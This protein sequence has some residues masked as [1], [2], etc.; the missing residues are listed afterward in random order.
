MGPV[1]IST[2]DLLGIYRAKTLHGTPENI[3]IYPKIH[4]LTNFQIGNSDITNEGMA[5]RKSN[6]LSPHASSVREYAYG[7]SLSRI[8]WR[9]TARSG[10]LMSK[11]F[12][13][14]TNNEIMILNDLDDSVHAGELDQS[15]FEL[16]ISLVASL[17]KKY[18]R[19]NTP[20]GFLSHGKERYHLPPSTGTSH[21]NRSMEILTRA[22]SG[23]D[24]KLQQ[25]LDENRNLWVTH[26]SIIIITPSTNIEWVIAL[27]ALSRF[28]ID[29][30]VI[31]IDPVS[32]S[33]K[34]DQTPVISALAGI[35]ISP[36][37]LTKE[38]SIEV[39]LS[40]SF[41]RKDD[42]KLVGLASR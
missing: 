14:G 32:F 26:T 42:A 1:E 25:I 18:S 22:Q 28:N 24:K 19:S 4:D 6:I 20:I 5:R 23:D 35:G 36:F 7:D 21:F 29:I 37:L 17:C 38:D 12:D 16:S 40:R 34:G 2:T 8:H 31:L 33:G 27:S 41:H 3:M 15:S 9:S 13:V 30:T 10:R 39:A 11:E